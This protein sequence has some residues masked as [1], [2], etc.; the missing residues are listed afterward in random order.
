MIVADTVMR[1]NE[2]ASDPA[3]PFAGRSSGSG[4][5]PW[6]RATSARRLGPCP[7]PWRTK[8]VNDA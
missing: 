4:I 5:E 6:A 7:E 2:W 1:L 3:V 8:G